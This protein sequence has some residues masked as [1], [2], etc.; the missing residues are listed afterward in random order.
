MNK[1]NSSVTAEGPLRFKSRGHDSLD[2][3]LLDPFRPFPASRV[4]PFPRG[5]GICREM[6]V[7]PDHHQP[8][9]ICYSV[10]TPLLSLNVEPFYSFLFKRSRS[11]YDKQ[12]NSTATRLFF[13]LCQNE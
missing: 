8:A 13:A 11:F 3:E 7:L 1:D 10:S 12:M 9:A 4:R 2:N 5:S 6:S